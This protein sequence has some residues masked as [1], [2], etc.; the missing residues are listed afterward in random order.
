MP[1]KIPWETI[2]P[3]G[4]LAVVILIIVFGF[5]LK[6]QKK[7]ISTPAPPSN[8][9][10]VSKKTLCFQ[11]EGRISSNETAIKMIGEQIKISDKNNLDAHEKMFGKL[12]DLGEKIIKEIHKQ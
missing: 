10:T 8:L 12:D 5:I 1:A 3:A 9:N 6:M 11:H 2:G 4:A 7:K